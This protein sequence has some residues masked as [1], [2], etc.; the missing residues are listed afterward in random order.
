[1]ASALRGIKVKRGAAWWEAPTRL[2]YIRG[3]D[4]GDT[5]DSRSI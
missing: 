4:T 2:D 1:M 5:G 3:G